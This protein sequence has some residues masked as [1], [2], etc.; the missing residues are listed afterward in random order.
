[1]V[2]GALTLVQVNDVHGYLE[3]HPELVW[4]AQRR[5]SPSGSRSTALCP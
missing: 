5:A 1:M 3:P 4:A 2:S